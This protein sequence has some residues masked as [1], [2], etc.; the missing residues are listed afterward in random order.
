[1]IKPE[2]QACAVDARNPLDARSGHHY[3]PP[4]IAGLSHCRA[5]R[6]GC[7]PTQESG[8]ECDGGVEEI[9]GLTAKN[10][11]KKVQYCL[12]LFF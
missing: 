8:E 11:A 12:V 7:G 10:Q 4:S 3:N 2:Y 6:F 1:M 5:A 9:I